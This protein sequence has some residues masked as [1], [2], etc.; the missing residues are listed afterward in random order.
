VQIIG[1]AVPD[2]VDLG[3]SFDSKNTAVNARGYSSQ[4]ES[5]VKFWDRRSQTAATARA[6]VFTCSR[7]EMTGSAT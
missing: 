3:D 7:M 1:S 4:P 6:F 5:D 2:G